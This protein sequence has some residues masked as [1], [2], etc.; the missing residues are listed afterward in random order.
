MIRTPF[1]A[2]VRDARYRLLAL[3][4]IAAFL[5]TT[6]LAL[7]AS[8]ADVGGET[9]PSSKHVYVRIANEDGARFDLY[10]N[11]TYYIK[12][13]G[14]GLNALHITTNPLDTFGQVTTTRAGNGTF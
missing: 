6:F 4:M 8:A 1:P 7:A 13:D 14:G 10:G 2:D 3:L 9:I 12:F 11:D 5:G